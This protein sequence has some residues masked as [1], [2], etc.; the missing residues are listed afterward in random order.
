MPTAKKAKKQGQHQIDKGNTGSDLGR[1]GQDLVRLVAALQLEE[2][3]A[4]H[5][6]H[7]PEG[8]G[9][10]DDPDPA[11]PLQD[12]A[13][14][15]QALRAVI[16][17]GDDGR[18]GGCQAGDGLEN[19]IG[20]VHPFTREP[21][22]QG[23]AQ[24]QREP[25]ADRQD[26]GGAGRDRVHRSAIDQGQGGPEEH[27][28]DGGQEEGGGAVMVAMRGVQHGGRQHQGCQHG[29]HH[30]HHEEDLSQGCGQGCP[31]PR[32]FTLSPDQC[33]WARSPGRSSEK[34]GISAAKLSPS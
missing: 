33:S 8:H 30:A 24:G 25:G 14:E 2:L 19:G 20:P 16:Q 21:H 32:R 34:P 6:Q 1:L 5:A 18:A 13:P 15:Q 27:A 17:P 22:G 7:G 31:P 26:E 9:G 4:A 3:H 12:R 28:Q 29:H 23:R 10:H 11:D